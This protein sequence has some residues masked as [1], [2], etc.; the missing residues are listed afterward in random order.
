MDYDAGIDV[1]LELS[2]VCILDASGQIIREA[3]VTREPE[4][5]TTFLA[6]LGLPLTRVG[7]EAGPLSQWLHAGLHKA[8]SDVVLLETRH[9]K[10]A[11][12]AR[13]VTT[14]RRDARGIAQLLR[15]GWFRPVP[16]KSPP[17]QEVRALLMARKQLQ[18][19]MRDVELSLRALLRGFGLKVGEVSKGQFAARVRTLTAGHQ[20]LEKIAEAMLRAREALQTEFARLHRAMLAIARDDT[21]CRRLMTVPGVGALI[22]VTFTAAVDQPERF[23]ALKRWALEVAKR[24]GMRRAKVA[25]ARK[26]AVIRHRM[27]VDGTT[28]RWSRE[29]AAA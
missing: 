1:S 4:A 2:R 24:R 13:I 6:D 14:D 16:C 9:V 8:G 20:M 22:A 5:L 26:L 17:A 12:S 21:V 25:L 23:S 27:W 10:A 11:L 29:G 15:M 3:K 19:K 28:F 7:L 18:A